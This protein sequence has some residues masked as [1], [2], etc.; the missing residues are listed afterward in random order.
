MSDT[1]RTDIDAGF[2]DYRVPYETL[3]WYNAHE[4]EPREEVIE[5]DAGA[6]HAHALN[7]SD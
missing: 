7:A 3:Y 1:V 4:R 6:G 5:H 2:S